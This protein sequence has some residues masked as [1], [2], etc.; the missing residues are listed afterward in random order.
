MSSSDVFAGYEDSILLVKND[1]S[2]YYVPAF[3]VATLDE[4]CPGE[5]YAIFLNGGDDIDFMYPMSLAS[6]SDD[7][8]EINDEYKIETRRNDV[9]VTGESH[10]VILDGISGKVQEG[11]ILRAYANSNL[12][13]SINIIDEHLEG[14]RPIDLVAH[15]SVDLSDW[16][17]PIL[18][19]Y[20]KGDEI[21]IRLFSIE[22]QVELRV[23]YDLNVNVYGKN[24][25]MSFGN[26][27][28]YD[29]PALPTDFRLVQNYPNPFN[30]TTTIDYN[31]ASNG[32]VSLKVYD[33]MGRLV[34]TLVDNQ[35]AVAGQTSDYSVTWNG[36]DDN[37][38]KVSAGLYIY[39]LQS[40]S[41][42]T[43]NKMILLK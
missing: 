24:E 3:G 1:A 2:E 36:L 30:P 11:D 38:Q 29:A 27:T 39:R 17:G 8:R 41:M 10:I 7:L 14:T 26:A 19:G 40:G 13:G 33:V 22:D 25:Q 35:W 31:V 4:M 9:A 42:S 16:N 32:F 34:K 12:V 15:G 21:E 18:S 6:L 37:S 20:D 43:S 23:D 28:V 5:A